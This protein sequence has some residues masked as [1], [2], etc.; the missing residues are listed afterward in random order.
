[1]KQKMGWDDMLQISDIRSAVT[2]I[3][4][5]YGVKRL[6]LFGSYAKGNANEN[7]DVDL[8]V[9]KGKPMSL[10]R[11]SG[12]RQQVEDILHISVDLVTTAGIE[13]EF[14]ECIAGTEIL[15]YEE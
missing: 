15:L 13:K 9:E 6:Y 5:D 11:I 3:A 12:M 7:S 10:L 8:L 2:P 14:Q 4:R 1:M